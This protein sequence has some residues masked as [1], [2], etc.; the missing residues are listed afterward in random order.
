MA[1]RGFSFALLLALTT[2]AVSPALAQD[3]A[4]KKSEANYSPIDISR[5]ATIVSTKGMFFAES[6]TVERL[7]FR[8]W[9]PK[10]FQGVPFHLVDPQG[11]KVPD[12]T[13]SG[14][15]PC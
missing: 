6:S 5:Y 12:S 1:V 14:S 2:A 3:G 7:V 9:K 10:T 15:H 4:K 13:L 11:D 8:D